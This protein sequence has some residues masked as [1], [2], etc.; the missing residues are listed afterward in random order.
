MVCPNAPLLPLTDEMFTM[1][2]HPRSA[3]PPHSGC[4]MLNIE[5]RLLRRTSDQF[6]KLI[7][8]RRASRVMPALLIRMS[9]WRPSR[10]SRP[11][12]DW[13]EA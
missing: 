6:S 11:I 9:I 8:R 2:P 4:V 10:S 1:R 12:N 3:M 13:Q 5:S 7:L